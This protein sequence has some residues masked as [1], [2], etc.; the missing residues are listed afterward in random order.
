[1]LELLKSNAF[2]GALAASIAFFMLHKLFGFFITK[3]QAHKVFKALQQGLEHPHKNRTFLPTT[4]L[5]S[6]T[7]YTT[8][9]VE[10]LCSKHSKIRRNEK[11]LESWC[12]K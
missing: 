6:K 8:Q 3:W 7:G 1:M 5:A 11:Q 4:F 10:L 2:V 9:K 12:L